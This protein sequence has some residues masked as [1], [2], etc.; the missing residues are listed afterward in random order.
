MGGRKSLPFS[1]DNVLTHHPTGTLFDTL[2]RA[3]IEHAHIAETDS[4]S[5]AAKSDMPFLVEQSGMIAMF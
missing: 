5:M 4:G 3:K 2:L 1:Y